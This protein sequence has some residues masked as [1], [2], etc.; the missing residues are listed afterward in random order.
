MNRLVPCLLVLLVVLCSACAPQAKV[1][2]ASSPTPETFLPMVSSRPAATPTATIVAPATPVPSATSG[3]LQTAILTPETAPDGQSAIVLDWPFDISAPIASVSYVDL[4]QLSMDYF[5][6]GWDDNASFLAYDCTQESWVPD[7]RER[8]MAHYVDARTQDDIL[9]S[10]AHDGLDLN[11]PE[12]TPMV[13]Q[14][15][16]TIHTE[17]DLNVVFL[18]N[19][20]EIAL[21]LGHIEYLPSYA[22]NTQYQVEKGD[23]VGW[24]HSPNGYTYRHPVTELDYTEIHFGIAFLK[25]GEAV[26]IGDYSGDNYT[27]VDGLVGDCNPNPPVRWRSGLEGLTWVGGLAPDPEHYLPQPYEGVPPDCQAPANC[28]L[29]VLPHPLVVGELQRV[30]LL[31]SDPS[32]VRSDGSLVFFVQPYGSQP[33]DVPDG[34]APELFQFVPDGRARAGFYKEGVAYVAVDLRLR[35]WGD[36][37]AA[38]FNVVPQ[39]GMG[40]SARNALDTDGCRI[41]PTIVEE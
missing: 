34:E 8:Y 14:W 15:D 6:S 21:K 40:F 27:V 26:R 36:V 12:G 37:W 17:G 4:D 13:S 32:Y 24:V 3:V 19:G 22:P 2:V 29:C 30:T 41:A 20:G 11:F 39:A 25:A 1:A 10:D 18:F 28:P 38:E 31:V 5:F 23:V 7:G 33:Q 35:P 16:T 9:H